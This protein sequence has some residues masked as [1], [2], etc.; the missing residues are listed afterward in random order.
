LQWLKT[1][2]DRVVYKY[3]QQKA[4]IIFGYNDACFFVDIKKIIG[5]SYS[6]INSVVKYN[7]GEIKLFMKELF[8]WQKN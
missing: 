3:I 6:R 7:R 4:S 8:I 1:K 2:R 5:Y